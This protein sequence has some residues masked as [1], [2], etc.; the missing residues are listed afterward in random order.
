[1][2]EPTDPQQPA[3]ADE[4]KLIAERRAKLDK[5]RVDSVGKGGWRSRTISAATRWPISCTP[6]TA[7]VRRNGSRPTRSA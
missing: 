1:M 7:I 4:N 6:R 5:L 3:A 2:T